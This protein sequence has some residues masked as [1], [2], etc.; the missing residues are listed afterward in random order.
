M[1]TNQAK[2]KLAQGQPVFGIIGSTNDPQI[3]EILGLLGFDFYMVDG[4]HGLINPVQAENMVRACEVANMTPLVRLGA[5]DPKLVLQYLD[6]G[7]MGVMMPGLETV[8]EMEMLVNAVKYPPVG[9]RG[10]GFGRAANF[11]LGSGSEQAEYVMQANGQTL[12][13]TQFEDAALLK[14]LPE[15]VQVPGVDAFVFGPRDLSLTMGFADDP[16]HPDVQAIIDEA[17]TII[18]AASL[19]VGI[20]AGTAVAAQ[21]QIERG[22][23]IILNTLPNLLRQGA[24]TF[25]P[26][27]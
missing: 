26:S 22:A 15:L 8:A 4:E 6:A 12:V 11:L 18:E 24:N 23:H 3:V 25:L 19:W 16:A 1:R 14:I 27:G 2:A 20:T 9:K 7:F 10:L 17:I 21:Q 13:L 5:K